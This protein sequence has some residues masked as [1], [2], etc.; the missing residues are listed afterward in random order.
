[1]PQ[2]KVEQVDTVEG[3]SHEVRKAKW[4]YFFVSSDLLFLTLSFKICLF[5]Q[6]V[7]LP[8]SDEYTSLKPRVG[9]AAKVSFARLSKYIFMTVKMLLF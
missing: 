6:Q 3:C 4:N 5:H 9:K 8:A 7:A 1:M 2:V